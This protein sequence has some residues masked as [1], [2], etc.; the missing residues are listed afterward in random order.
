MHV[1]RWTRRT[2]SAVLAVATLALL[3]PTSAALAAP[4][5]DDPVEAA[6]GWLATQ[7][8]DDERIET[9]FDGATYPDQGL[10]ADTVFAL[11]GAGVAAGEI[12]DT[13]DWLEEQTGT[14][15]GTE[16]DEVYAGAVAKLLIV[17][18]V[19]GRDTVFG[20]EDLVALLEGRQDEEGR[21]RDDSPWGDFSNTITQS[22]ALIALQR[23]DGVSPSEEAVTYLGGQACDDGSFPEVLDPGTCSGAVD[24]TAFAIQ[25]ASAVG[26]TGVVEAAGAWL[27]DE[28]A[29]DGSFDGDSPANANSTGL[30]AAALEVA[31]ETVAAGEAR[32]F[33]LS[34]QEGCD[35]AEPGSLRFTADDPGDRTRATAQALP[36]LTATSLVTVS[37]DGAGS[38]VPVLDCEDDDNGGSGDGGGGT[39]S[40]G[41]GDGA[42]G[43]GSG[44][45]TG[46]ETGSG[47]GDDGGAGTPQVADTGLEA[48]EG[49]PTEAEHDDAG[50]GHE[51]VAA[52][53]GDAEAELPATGGAIGA[54]VGLAAA[55]FAAGLLAL[56]TTARARS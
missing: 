33:V 24:A 35:A 53:A 4:V 38:E 5:T 30:A 41:S 42:D 50:G 21:F 14:Y 20:G 23:V 16:N 49:G 40:G 54:L 52:Q 39:G 56:R 10:T 46:A 51:I 11:A 6:A 25:A 7:L 43:T 3:A 18:D 29:G 15:T 34:L 32:D 1:I 19:T 13:T 22:L 48:A 26:A 8:V 44:G 37:A 31:G 45:S 12:E 28:Q 55:L 17:A 2:A 47:T 27:V 36:G 9:T